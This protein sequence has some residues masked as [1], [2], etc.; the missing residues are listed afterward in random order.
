MN[1]STLTSEEFRQSVLIERERLEAAEHIV[2]HNSVLS[3]ALGRNPVFIKV[4]GYHLQVEWE[5]Q[6]YWWYIF[7]TNPL[8][9]VDSEWRQDL[10]GGFWEYA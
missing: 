4:T 3:R 9:G 1:K 6:K 8:T 5:A 7:G 10:H 2:I